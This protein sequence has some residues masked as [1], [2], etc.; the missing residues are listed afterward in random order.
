MS[1][2]GV[3]QRKLLTDM[4]VHGDGSWPSRWSM[5]HDD[6]MIIDSLRRRGYVDAGRLHPELTESGRIMAATLHGDPT[7]TYRIVR[8]F[9]GD[10]PTLIIRSGLSIIEARSWCNRPETHGTGWF[11]GYERES[12]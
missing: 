11:D 7:E 6:R 12:H 5:R 2:L 8:Y 3:R 10:D 4:L 9:R 1:G